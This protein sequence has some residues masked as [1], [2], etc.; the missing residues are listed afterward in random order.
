M[1]SEVLPEGRCACKE[2]REGAVAA[3]GPGYILKT[4]ADQLSWEWET[5]SRALGCCPL[6][7]LVL[8]MCHISIIPAFSA[9]WEWMWQGWEEAERS[10]L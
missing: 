2:S 7:L 8:G 10:C 9:E 1:A 5:E 6:C 3:S 4:G